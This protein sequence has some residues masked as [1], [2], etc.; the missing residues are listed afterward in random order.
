MLTEPSLMLVLVMPWSVTPPAASAA[1]AAAAAVPEW[2][3][4]LLAQARS[5]PVKLQNDF[6]DLLSVYED[7]L[8]AYESFMEFV[9]VLELLPSVMAEN[10]DCN[11]FL[12]KQVSHVDSK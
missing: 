4:Q 2:T 10:A 11:E 5:N 8:L 7:E 1:S 9:D 6:R 12:L 3:T